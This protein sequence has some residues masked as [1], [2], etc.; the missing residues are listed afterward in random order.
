MKKII[1]GIVALVP[2]VSFAQQPITNANS[3]VT[4]LTG[5]GTTFIGILIA[6]GVIFIVWHAV[7]FILKASDPEGRK[8]H[9][10]GILWGVVGLAVIFSIWGLVAILKG[11]FVTSDR[12]GGNGTGLIPTP[13]ALNQ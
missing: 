1:A 2:M 11:T 5:L 6:L 3:L 13:P 8:T 9:G 10:Q 4:K 7:M 12:P